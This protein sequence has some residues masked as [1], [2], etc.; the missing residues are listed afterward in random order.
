MTRDKVI[1]AF[2][3]IRVWTQG[4]RRDCTNDGLKQ[5]RASLSKGLLEEFGPDGSSNTRYYPFWHLQTDGLWQLDGP[6]E[7]LNRP[8]GAQCQRFTVN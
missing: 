7:I 1:S 8:A 5:C 2:N 6:A 4:E 3:A